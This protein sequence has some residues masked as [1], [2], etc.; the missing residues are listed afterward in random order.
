MRKNKSTKGNDT[1]TADVFT[2]TESD[3]DQGTSK[4]PNSLNSYFQFF[5]LNLINI[6]HEIIHNNP[7]AFQYNE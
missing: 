6:M 5:W 2:R 7:S 4:C 1:Q 3:I